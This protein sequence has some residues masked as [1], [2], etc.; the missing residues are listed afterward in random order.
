MTRNLAIDRLTIETGG[1]RRHDPVALKC[2]I[3]R[4]LA[5][6]IAADGA[7]GRAAGGVARGEAERDGG[8]AAEI[9]ARIH[10]AMRR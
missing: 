4:R 9:A 7:G 1:R 8:L 2:E 5:A 10:G 3:E 6:L